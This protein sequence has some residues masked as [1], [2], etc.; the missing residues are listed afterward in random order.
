MLRSL[1]ARLHAV[2]LEGVTVYA[3][4]YKDWLARRCAA[5]CCSHLPRALRF[6]AFTS[7]SRVHIPFLYSLHFLFYALIFTIASATFHLSTILQPFTVCRHQ[8]HHLSKSVAMNATKMRAL[9]EEVGSRPKC[10]DWGTKLLHVCTQ[11][12]EAFDEENAPDQSL[13]ESLASVLAD[14]D[15]F[16]LAQNVIVELRPGQPDTNENPLKHVVIAQT[17][18]LK[19]EW[20][21]IESTPQ[22]EFDT[23]IYKAEKATYYDSSLYR[24]RLYLNYAGVFSA[25]EE[26]AVREWLDQCPIISPHA[27]TQGGEGGPASSKTPFVGQ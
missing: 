17:S 8:A 16:R 15:A 25:E 27:G 13:A 1:V 22:E 23:A 26:K 5:A 21:A 7:S 9:L 10:R 11:L 12:W 2:A 19:Q 14:P 18:S 3:T 6:F 20:A 24:T 4:R